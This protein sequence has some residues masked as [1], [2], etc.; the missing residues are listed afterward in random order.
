MPYDSDGAISQLVVDWLRFGEEEQ[1]RVQVGD[2]IHLGVVIEDEQRQRG[3]ARE[4]VFDQC[5]ILLS[6]QQVVVT[7]LE[8][9]ERDGMNPGK[10]E[11]RQRLEA[12]TVHAEHPELEVRTVPLQ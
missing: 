3:R 12:N 5:P 4:I 9:V 8:V 2:E 7:L 1:V 10:G 11:S 6:R